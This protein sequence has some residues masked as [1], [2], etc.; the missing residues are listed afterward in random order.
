MDISIIIL[1]RARHQLVFG[2]IP[3]DVQ[4]VCLFKGCMFRDHLVKLP[5]NKSSSPQENN[6]INLNS[7]PVFDQLLSHKDVICIPAKQVK[8]K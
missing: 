8:S 4:F 6:G 5:E 7:Q 2:D 1:Q 3:I